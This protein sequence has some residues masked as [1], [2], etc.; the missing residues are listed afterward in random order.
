MRLY[1]LHGRLHRGGL[2]CR[3][4]GEK[5]RATWAGAQNRLG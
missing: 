5:A 1:I 2:S 3:R 4:I